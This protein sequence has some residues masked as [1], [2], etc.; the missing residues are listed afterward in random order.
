M[1]ACSLDQISRVVCLED[2]QASRLQ[3]WI[4]GAMTSLLLSVTLKGCDQEA[5]ALKDQGE[6]HESKVLW[7]QED[8]YSCQ[9]GRFQLPLQ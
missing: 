2:S 4:Y 6:M 5:G 8:S 7:C 9:A 3:L 1:R